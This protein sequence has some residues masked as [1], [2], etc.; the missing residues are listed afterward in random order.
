MPDAA[1]APFRHTRVL[2]T[3]LLFATLAPRLL[4]LAHAALSGDEAIFGLMALAIA[5]GSEYPLYCWGA[6]YASALISYL[7]VPVMAV[8]GINT[9]ALKATTLLYSVFLVPL[10]FFALR[11]SSGGAVAFL[12]ALAVALPPPVVF[13]YSL[14]VVGGYPETFFLGC[15]IWLVTLDAVARPSA[16]KYFLLGLLMGA[17]FT[18]LWLGLP[19]IA[20]ALVLVLLRRPDPRH[21]AIC[22]AGAL[23]ATLPFWYYNL[24]LHP[25]AT[26]LRLGARSLE[27]TARTP[28]LTAVTGRLLTTGQWCV[29]SAAGLNDLGAPWGG[30]VGSLA[31]L[32][33]TLAGAGK[34]L[35]SRREEG[36]LLFAFLAGLLVFNYLGNLTRDRM[37]TPL[38]FAIVLALP[39][40][41]RKSATALF[42]LLIAANSFALLPLVARSSNERQAETLAR[43]I[44]SERREGLVADYDLGYPVAFHAGGGLPVAAVAPPNPSD[45]RPDWT[46]A[47]RARAALAVIL[48]P[49]RG[50]AF[51]EALVRA[52]LA[53]R[54]VSV[55][56]RFV[57][58][59]ETAG[60]S[61]VS[62]FVVQR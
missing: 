42:V 3:L 27:A 58:L 5:R 1:D 22:A 41:G 47:V 37:W 56:D 57:Y 10:L 18:I 16:A 34:F 49:D 28:L 38:Y 2:I 8:L 55:G 54:R 11:R 50:A 43:L 17:S 20:S 21:L 25:G 4:H 48:P 40:F 14:A 30:I 26:F 13:S 19:F 9:F 35:K 12:A 24:V 6:H 29:E 45:R 36:I 51:E 7:A 23:I 53:F 31:L 62:A 59:T 52:G 15:A 33:L 39:A 44:R 60:D 32:G 61:V 46:E